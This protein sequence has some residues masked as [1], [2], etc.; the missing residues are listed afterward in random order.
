MAKNEGTQQAQAPQGDPT[1]AWENIQDH[2]PMWNADA[3]MQSCTCDAP[4]RTNANLGKS[5][6][7]DGCPSQVRGYLLGTKEMNP[8]NKNVKKDVALEDQYWMAVV[9]QLTSKTKAMSQEK[10]VRDFGPG[11]QI[12]VGGYD[13]GS[14]YG[15]ADHPSLAFEVVIWPTKKI[16]VG[17]GHNM[18]LFAKK[19]NPQVFKREEH[20]LM[21][22][23]GRQAAIEA[24]PF[25]GAQALP[26]GNGPGAGAP[27]L[28]QGARA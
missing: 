23:E 15:R 19:V 28:T 7:A 26:S 4:T 1:A 18:W 6:H 13:L 5:P 11:D 10:E 20:G 14:L 3:M 27:A 9:V 12:L 16:S 17:G 2:R 25:N 8:S 22:Y 21:F 24:D